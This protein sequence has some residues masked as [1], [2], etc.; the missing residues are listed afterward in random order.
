MPGI[1]GYRFGFVPAADARSRGL[2][3]IHWLPSRRRTFFETLKRLGSADLT[4]RSD[5]RSDTTCRF[6]GPFESQFQ[7][8]ES[9]GEVGG[10]V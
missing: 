10:T 8:I 6:L 7:Q 3:G 4:L 1:A 5:T 2:E 9:E